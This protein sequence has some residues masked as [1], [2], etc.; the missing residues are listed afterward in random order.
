MII[1]RSPRPL[2]LWNSRTPKRPRRDPHPVPHPVPHRTG[3]SVVAAPGTVSRM[4]MTSATA[5]TG[6]TRRR[7]IKASRQSM[8]PLTV[9]KSVNMLSD[10]PPKILRTWIFEERAAKIS[11]R[12]APP[13]VLFHRKRTRSGRKRTGRCGSEKWRWAGSESG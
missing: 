12:R 10:T 2:V 8:P 3:R 7:G 5:A 11:E 4:Y 13:G 6:E 1:L 9:R